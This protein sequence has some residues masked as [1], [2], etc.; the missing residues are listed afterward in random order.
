MQGNEVIPNG[1]IIIE[2]NRIVEVGS[3]GD[4]E[5]PSNTKVV[6]ATGKTIIPGIIDIHAHPRPRREIFPEQCATF[7][8]HLAYGIT[9]MFDPDGWDNNA[10]F[11]TAEL[12]EAGKLVGPRY[13]GTGHGLRPSTVTINSLEDAQHV[14]RRY[15]RQGA[16]ALKEYLRNTRT[17]RQWLAMAAREEGLNITAEG[18]GYFAGQMTHVLDGYTGFEHWI[19]VAPLYKDVIDIMA[20][21]KIS[22]D[23]TIG[24]AF[25][26]MQ[27]Q[28]YFRQSANLH[29]DKKLR[30]FVNHDLF[31]RYTR[32]VFKGVKEDFRFWDLAAAAAEIARNGGN[33]TVG[34]HEQK[35]LPTHWEIWAYVLGGMMPHDALQAA[36]IKGAQYLGM[37][38]D[39]GSLEP[40]KLADLLVLNRNPLDDIR[41]STDIRYVMKNGMLFDAETLDAIWPEREEFKK[42]YWERQEEEYQEIRQGQHLKRYDS[43][44]S[45]E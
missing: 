4:V 42:F 20:Q 11:G 40:G 7:A 14:A 37:D 9:T 27:A 1:T 26:A 6:D 30:R 21:S 25:G 10:T 5:I 28:Y 17:E 32:R 19:P 22:Y 12:I 35:G 43:F 31:D 41:N 39:L 16:I 8:A 13:Y 15:R 24:V 36:T 44:L 18:I 2:N 3:I 23:L 29:K 33:I 45:H 38:E 34:G